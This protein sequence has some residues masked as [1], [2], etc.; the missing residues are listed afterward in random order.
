M[1]Q[2]PFVH[3]IPFLVRFPAFVAAATYPVGQLFAS[4]TKYCEF[5]TYPV[6]QDSA[7]DNTPD[8]KEM[9]ANRINFFIIRPFT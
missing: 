5:S 8:M 2:V 4:N 9:H 6:G 7:A 1:L 3:A